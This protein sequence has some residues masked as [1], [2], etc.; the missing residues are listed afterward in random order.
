MAA[1]SPP[2]AAS[3]FEWEMREP[4]SRESSGE[5]L[6]SRMQLPRL[7]TCQVRMARAWLLQRHH[8]ALSLKHHVLSRR[9]NET[10]IMII[11]ITVR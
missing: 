1:G 5:V 6:V 3:W 9:R 4:F 11:L 10:T 8:G 2:H 7:E